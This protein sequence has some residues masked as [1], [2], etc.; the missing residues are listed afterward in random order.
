V[1][2][3]RTVYN[4][5]PGKENLFRA[6]IQRATATAEAFVAVHV[7][8]GIGTGDVE[9]EIRE[10]ARIHAR[11]VLAPQ[12]I[13]TRRL[14]IGETHRFPE[15]AAD[16]FERVPAAVMRAIAGRL[17]RYDSLG[18]LQVPDPARAAE[19]FAYLVLG[20]TLDRAL[21][22]T[23]GPSTAVIDRTAI[24]GAAVFFCAYRAT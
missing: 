14:L 13:A 6:V 1:L 9:E 5:F 3:K 12:V 7:D 2:A 22:D 18:L 8:A 16:Y 20:A 17:E 21:F 24:A 11:A 15:L 10:F 23:A 19:H 4:V